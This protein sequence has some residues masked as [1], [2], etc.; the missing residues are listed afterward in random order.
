MRK[1]H[2]WRVTSAQERKFFAADMRPDRVIR[3]PPA[4][5]EVGQLPGRTAYMGCGF[6]LQIFAEP[7]FADVT[8]VL[9]RIDLGVGRVLKRHSRM[10]ENDRQNRCRVESVVQSVS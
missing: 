3:S 5:P 2:D 1:P 8:K 6:E 7:V 4:P 10:Q 9:P